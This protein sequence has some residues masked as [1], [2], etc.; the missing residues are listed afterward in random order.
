MRI[1]CYIDIVIWSLITDHRSG[2]TA[3]YAIS[4]VDFAI[5]SVSSHLFL[6]T[7]HFKKDRKTTYEP[8]FFF[9]KKWWPLK[10]HH[11]VPSFLEE[12]KEE[13]IWVVYRKTC[14]FHCCF[15]LSFLFLDTTHFST[16]TKNVEQYKTTM[17]TACFCIQYTNHC[18]LLLLPKVM[19]L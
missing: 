10:C 2:R 12:E 1:T 19:A 11:Q 3:N 16:T 4:F 8:F 18:V 14:S 6:D 9:F 17:K 7:T 5:S 15:V 13:L